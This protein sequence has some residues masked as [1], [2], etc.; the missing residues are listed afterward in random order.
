[1]QRRWHE[2]LSGRRNWQ[3]QLWNVLMFEAWLE[4]AR[5]AN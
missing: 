2:H 3:Y 4:A 5:C 1:V